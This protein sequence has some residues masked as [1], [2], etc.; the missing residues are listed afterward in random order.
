MRKIACSIVAL[1]LLVP[2]DAEAQR[3][4]NMYRY[5]AYSFSPYAGVL[6]DAFDAEPDGSNLGWIAG[7]RAGYT[8]S[9]RTNFHL[10]LG[11]AQTGDVAPRPLVGDPV[12][13]DNQWVLL[14][15]GGDFALVP[16]NTSVALGVDLGVG[17]LRTR[18]VQ[19]EA[20]SGRQTWSAHDVV[21]PALI[22]RHQFTPRAGVYVSAQDYIFDL[23]NGSAQHSPAFT[24]GLTI[25]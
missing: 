4:G 2:A 5:N 15:A 13:V 3:R 19:P 10:N 21:A 14:T 7:F 23:L 1:A 24:F 11:Y 9:E 22:V 8:E 6:M 20:G 16:G 18:P 17:W 12:I 25:R